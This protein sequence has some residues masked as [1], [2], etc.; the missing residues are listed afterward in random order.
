MQAI[1]DA[2]KTMPS[3]PGVYR[4]LGK[5]DEV[6]YVGKAK[7]LKK[8]VTNYIHPERLC[9]RIGIMVMNTARMEI[10]VT[11]DEAEALR[12]ECDLI[13]SLKP[14]YNILLTDDKSFPHIFIPVTR[15]FPPL[16]KH[17]G[18]H[19]EKGFYFGPL[20]DISSLNSSLAFLQKMFLLRSC[21]DSV[22]RTRK[23]ACLLYQIGRCSAPCAGKISPEEY[24]KQI[25]EAIAFLSGKNGHLKKDLMKKMQEASDNLE[26]ELAAEYRDKIKFLEQTVKGCENDYYEIKKA[27]IIVFVNSGDKNII[28]VFFVR[29]EKTVGNYSYLFSDG[30]IDADTALSE[31]I[32]R[33]YHDREVPDMI[34]LSHDISEKD[35]LSRAMHSHFIV[36]KIG[37]KK[38]LVNLVI[39]NAKTKLMREKSYND[40]NNSALMELQSLLGIAEISRVEIYDN[41]HLSGTNPVGAMVCFTKNGWDKNSYRRYNIKSGFEQ[42]D[43]N[44]MYEVMYRRFSGADKDIVPD[45]ILLD[46]GKLQLSAFNQA[47]SNLGKTVNVLCIAK[48]EKR[49]DGME[50]FYRGDGSEIV[51][52]LK[53]ELRFFLERLRDEAHRFVIGF[54]RFKREKGV[55]KK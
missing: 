6:L 1:K 43:F 9:R 40:K 53:T 24:K 16:L 8:R 17:R 37:A 30:D 32:S 10:I 12:L 41:S 5:N 7:N 19:K 27:D 49:N 14:K 28:E 11:R 25:D 35:I 38:A 47:M 18:S 13:K 3:C 23:R 36:P 50:R 33:F 34:I 48:G 29:G 39:D 52:P 22:F 55:F 54:Q 51:I 31:F 4:M 26:Y 46:G 45:L 42:S 21:K 15:P 44:M 2:L 20:T